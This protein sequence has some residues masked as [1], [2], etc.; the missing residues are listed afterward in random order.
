MIWWTYDVQGASARNY[1]DGQHHL[2][3]LVS[4]WSGNEGGAQLF[5]VVDNSLT[6]AQVPNAPQPV[7][8][9]AGGGYGP[10]FGAPG[11]APMPGAPG[12]PAP[13]PGYGPPMF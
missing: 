3:A 4:D 12:V 13:A 8:F 2:V 6:Y 1:P 7:S 5:F 11:G 9:G 10:G